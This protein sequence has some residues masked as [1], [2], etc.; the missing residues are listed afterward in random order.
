MCD[1]IIAFVFLLYRILLT[2]EMGFSVNILL[3]NLRKFT[4]HDFVLLSQ[5]NVTLCNKWD[6]TD[7]MLF[8]T[9]QCSLWMI[10]TFTVNQ[11]ETF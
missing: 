3:Q 8:E 7:S 5:Y 1:V 10:D 6:V 9:Y 4:W 2:L 11:I